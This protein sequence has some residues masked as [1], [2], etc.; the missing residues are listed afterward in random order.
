MSIFLQKAVIPSETMV[1][2]VLK[3]TSQLWNDMIKWVSEEYGPVTEEWTFAGK[4]NGWS[5]RLKQK[6]R[7]ILY[8]IPQDGY[9][10]NAFVFGD[11]AADFILQ[12]DFPENVKQSLR[13]ARRYMEGRGIRLDVRSEDAIEIIKRLVKVK[14][15][16]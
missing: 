11:K 4:N 6:K 2:D 12:E 9:F 16:V 8:F 13:E 15:S 10:Q 3:E 1:R 5:F 7:T 14:M